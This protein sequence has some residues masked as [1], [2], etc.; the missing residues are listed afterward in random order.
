M[1]TMLLGAILFLAPIVAGKVMT[2]PHVDR[3]TS[4]V[5]HP[6]S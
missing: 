2:P 5:E 4:M 6:A 1:A 3:P